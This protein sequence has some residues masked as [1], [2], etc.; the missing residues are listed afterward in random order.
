MGVTLFEARFKVFNAPSN[1]FAFRLLTAP[2]GLV[3]EDNPWPAIVFKRLPNV[4][5]T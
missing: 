4:F 5:S 3:A 1:V 2:V